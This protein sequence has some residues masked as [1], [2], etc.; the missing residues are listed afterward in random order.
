MDWPG[1]LTQTCYIPWRPIPEWEAMTPFTFV[2]AADL[3][4][5]SPFKGVSARFSLLCD[6]PATGNGN[7]L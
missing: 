6:T 7:R 5:G 3:H 4:L 1:V 2:H